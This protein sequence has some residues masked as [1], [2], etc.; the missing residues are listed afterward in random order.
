MAR[1]AKVFVAARE[2]NDHAHLAADS[3]SKT[4]VTRS[5]PDA[6][7]SALR[8]KRSEVQTVD[9][10]DM[11]THAV[12]N[13]MCEKCGREEVRF[14]TQQLRSADEGSTVFY[15][16]ECGHKYAFPGAH[17]SVSMRRVV[18]TSILQMEYQQLRKVTYQILVYL[19]E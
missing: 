6:F 8:T 2:H 17:V 19:A 12:I 11:Q 14:Y 18:L 4:V 10:S 9:D 13:Q 3:S 1:P 15:E 16:C 5:K 7:P